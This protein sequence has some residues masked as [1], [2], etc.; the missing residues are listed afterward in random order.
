IPGLSS[1]LVFEGKQIDPDNLQAVKKSNVLIIILS[2]NYASSRWCLGELVPMME[3]KNSR[4]HVVLPI[5]YEVEPKDV[6]HQLGLLGERFWSRKKCVDEKVV[7]EWEKALTEIRSLK[8][9]DSKKDVDRYE[10]DL[11]NLVV[12]KV[13]IELKKAFEVVFTDHRIENVMILVYHNSSTTLWDGWYWQD[14]LC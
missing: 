9:W 4:G 14:S 10:G 8:G 1:W 2:R 11:V 12:I 5:L 6:K 7:D 13:L 3:C